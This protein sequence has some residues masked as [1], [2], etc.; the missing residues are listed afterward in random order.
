MVVAPV[1]AA[2]DLMEFV[3]GLVTVAVPEP[4]FITRSSRRTPVGAGM[5]SVVVPVP[6]MSTARVVIDLVPMATSVTSPGLSPLI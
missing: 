2:A 6:L 5:F 1:G 3:T 4:P